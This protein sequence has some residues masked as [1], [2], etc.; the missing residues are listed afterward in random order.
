LNLK[1]PDSM[2][3]V[4]GSVLR[5]GVI[6]SASVII[7]GT[8]LLS[9]A[10]GFSDA[11]RILT[12]NPET[13]PHDNFDVSLTGLLNGLLALNP[14]SVIELGVILLIASPVSRVLVSVFLFLAEGDRLYVL[15]TSMVLALLLF[16]ILV[17]PFI[18]VFRA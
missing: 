13:I 9:V 12:Y 14:F 11:S 6:A 15:V 3:A 8:L 17:A 2:N 1:D 5:Y 7:F 4:I 16:S 18:P 10:S